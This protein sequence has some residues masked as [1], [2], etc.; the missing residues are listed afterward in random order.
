MIVGVCV[1][2]RL[3]NIVGVSLRQGRWETLAVGPEDVGQ[4][5]GRQVVHLAVERVQQ[6]RRRRTV[7]H[8]ALLRGRQHRTLHFGQGVVSQG[9]LLLDLFLP[10]LELVLLLEEFDV[11]ELDL[12]S[13]EQ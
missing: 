9:R 12:L 5:F 11:L 4:L 7:F 3:S 1:C 6:C 13:K 2:V 8:H 10:D